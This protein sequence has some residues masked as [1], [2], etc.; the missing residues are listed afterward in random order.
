MDYWCVFTHTF[1]CCLF[2]KIQIDEALKKHS[3]LYVKRVGDFVFSLGGIVFLFP[4][5]ISLILIL[6]FVN[7]GNPFFIQKRPG[8][9]GKIFRLIKFKTMND[10]AELSDIQRLTPVG[11]FLRNTSLDELPQ[12]INVLKG[13][14]SLVGPR[15]LLEEYLPLYSEEQARRH[16]IRPGITG[17]AQV[18]GRNT[19]S[20][21]QKF[22]YDIWYIDHVSFFLDL[23]I[24]GMTLLK[25]FKFKEVNA[26]EEITMERFAGN[27]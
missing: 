5:G 27:N 6:L 8:K 14:M 20:W 23:K 16:E 17:W 26:A 3:Y 7:R 4:I 15:P 2:A 24:I 22:R 10:Q 9:D 18:N 19:L 25:I 13:D 11:R 12:L 21:Q 1:K